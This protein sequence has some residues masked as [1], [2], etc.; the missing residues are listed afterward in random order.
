RRDLYPSDDGMELRVARLF[1]NP[2]WNEALE[3]VPRLANWADPPDMDHMHPAF[4]YIPK[5]M[6]HRPTVN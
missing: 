1:R 4:Q 2:A 3:L 5:W 6:E